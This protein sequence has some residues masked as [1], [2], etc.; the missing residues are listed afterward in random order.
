MKKVLITIL[1]VFYLGVSSGA[2]LH[3]HYCMGQLIDLGLTKTTA[4]KCDNCGM[5]K[6]ESQDCCKDQHQEFKAE[7]AQKASQNIYKFNSSVDIPVLALHELQEMYV[8]SLKA[9]HLS[10]NAPP[11]T[12]TIP[13]FIRN[14]SF[15]I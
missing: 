11:R 1:A 13:A 3:L 14:C 10:D 6:A 12:Q 4:D 8:S 7:K 9:E 15:R 5:N 2:T